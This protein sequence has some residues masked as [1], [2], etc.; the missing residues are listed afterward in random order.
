M[1]RLPC[2]PFA[3]FE[4]AF[5]DGAD[6]LQWTGKPYYGG[7]WDIHVVSAGR[8]FTAQSSV[9]QHP[10]GLPYELVARSA[11]SGQVLWRRPIAK[12]FGESASLMVA[13]PEQLFLKDGGRVLVLEPETGAKIRRIAATDD[14]LQQCLWLLVSDASRL[15]SDFRSPRRHPK[16]RSHRPFP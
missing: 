12:D 6:E 10:P 5:P 8:M 7:H 13:T 11:Y 1:R 16:P 14:Q 3:W 9:F 15:I 2:Q 4:A